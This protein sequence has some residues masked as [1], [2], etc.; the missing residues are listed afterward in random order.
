MA[1]AS[2]AFALPVTSASIDGGRGCS[3]SGCTVQ[4]FAWSS[5]AGSAGSGTLTLSAGTLTFSFTAPGATFVA[6]PGPSDN[7]VT[8]IDFSSVTYTGSASVSGVGFYTITG[9]SAS[10]SGTQTPTGAGSAGPFSAADSLLAGTCID[11]GSGLSCGIIFSSLNDFGFGV[12][13]QTRYF[14]HTV[15]VAAVPEP[16]T[17]LLLGGGLA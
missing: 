17:L 11:M 9:G 7:G 13:G 4:T 2:S 12:N 5:T 6:S 8:Q 14:T 15:D 3:D 1:V 10:I 16:S